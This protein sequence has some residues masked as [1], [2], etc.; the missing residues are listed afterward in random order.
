MKLLSRLG[1]ALAIGLLAIPMMATPVEA[2]PGF[3]L[4]NNTSY[5]DLDRDE[6]YIGDEVR[7]YGSW[8]DTHGRYIYIYYELYGEDE[9]D[10]YYKKVSYEEHDETDGTYS[11]DYDLEIPES[12]K[13][14]HDILICDDDDPDEDVAT[15]EFTIHPL[16]EIDEEEGAAGTEVGVTG[17][18][19][20]EDE[21]EIEI[22]FYLEDPDDD[23]DDKDLYEVA[24]S[25]DIEVDE[26]GSW[27]DVTF[28]V[29]H[30]SKGEHWIYAVGDESDDIEDDA[31]LGVEFEVL[32][33]ISLDKESGGFGETVTVT[34]SGF[35]EDEKGI[36]ILFDDKKVAGDIE[37][38]DDGC[39]EGTFEV[40]EAAKGT[41]DVTAE[42]RKTKEEDI[43]EVEFEVLPGLTL[44]PTQGHVG[45]T[46]T[47]R[48]GGFLANKPVTITYDGV[49]K[50]SSTTSSK[51]TLSGISFEATHT[52]T[53]HTV[54]HTVVATY[55][56]TTLSTTFI[57]ESVAPAKPTLSSPVNDSR[58]GFFGKQTATFTWSEVTDDSGVSYNLQIGTS[59]DFAQVLIS[60]TGLTEV[61]YI[62][63]GAEALDYGTYYWRVKAI[64]GAQNDSGWTTAYSFKSGFLPLWAFIVIV[65]LIVVLIGV[66]VFVFGIRGRTSYD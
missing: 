19:W 34:G 23:Y 13:G 31:I 29:P 52:Q 6:G 11:F 24:W 5:T 36:E 4:R 43:D 48:G 12:C 45:T 63:T 39:W 30:A 16:I 18:G 64:D 40:P 2:N 32:P 49:T 54:E 8:D 7:I 60:K 20:D 17:F 33:G 35:E 42:G 46:L 37:A 62:L 10:W 21:S 57:M 61:T 50:G 14:I 56:A 66:L 44:T 27:E 28:K 15:L 1:I 59:A 51:G 38:D 47:I 22:R 41:H 65:A 3:S 55:D 26:Y 53:T 58:L 25:G 9:E